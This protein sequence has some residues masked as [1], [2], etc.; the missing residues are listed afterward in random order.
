MDQLMDCFIKA[1]KSTINKAVDMNYNYVFNFFV[2]ILKFKE[3]SRYFQ[4]HQK[5]NS[6]IYLSQN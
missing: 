3:G 1:N 4:M 5:C 2:N 6:V